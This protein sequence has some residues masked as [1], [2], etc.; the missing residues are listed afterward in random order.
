MLNIIKDIE[1]KKG[2]GTFSENNEAVQP[3]IPETVLSISDAP[4][5]F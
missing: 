4:S 2:V 1:R 5:E 3:L